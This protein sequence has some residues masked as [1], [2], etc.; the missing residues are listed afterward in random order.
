MS[1]IKFAMKFMQG[2]KAKYLLAILCIAIAAGLSFMAPLVIRLTVDSVLAGKD[3]DL[4]FGMH[5]YIKNIDVIPFLIRNIWIAGLAIFIIHLVSQSFTYLRSKLSVT[6]AEEFSR[7]LRNAIYQHVQ[8][9]PYA[10]HSKVQT[11]DIVQRATSDINTIRGFLSSQLVQLGRG[12]FMILLLIPIMLSLSPRM[13]LIST[14]VVPIVFI[15]AFFFFRQVKS[16]FKVQDEAEGYMTTVLEESLSGIRVVRSFA[17][18]DYEIDRFDRAAN[19]YRQQSR[20]L[21]TVL[22]WY[23]SSSD[24]LIMTQMAITLIFGIRYTIAGTVSLGTLLAFTSYNGMLLW[25]IREMG[26][27]LTDMGR[28]QV[29]L[30]RI[31]E[32]LD[33][34]QEKMLGYFEMPDRYRLRGKIDFIDLS[35]AYEPDNPILNNINLSIQPG[36][37]IAVLGATGAGKSTLTNLI[38]RLFD[39]E[40]GKIRIDGIDLKKYDRQQLRRQIGIVLQEPFLYSRSVKDNIGIAL[41]DPE[42]T[43][44]E[45]AASEAALHESILEFENGYDTVIGEKGITLSGGQRQRMAIA[46]ALILDPPILILDDALSAVDSETE[47]EIQKNLLLR[48]GKSTTIIITHRLTSTQIADRILVLEH[49]KI[50]QLGTHQELIH[51]PGPYQ[52]I[53]KIQHELESEAV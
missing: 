50:A 9:L 22:A 30:I 43:S 36:E 49:G 28:A 13:T 24:V 2:L 19:D 42:Q 5:N 6:C 26:R 38:P 25:P 52:R 51:S 37:T 10:W 21:I 48:K 7:R 35:F 18:E 34:P 45:F 33:T 29:S 15:Y 44:I 53:W 16:R 11:G 47:R 46:R 23:W 12:I 3:I 32:I 14:I 4:P 41:Q 31:K 17:R 1:A 20:K 27:I 39:Y 40:S 8:L